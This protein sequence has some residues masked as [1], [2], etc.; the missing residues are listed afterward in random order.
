MRV[1]R[2]PHL[3][4]GIYGPQG[5]IDPLPFV[6][7]GKSTP[8]KIA[9]DTSRVGDTLRIARQIGTGIARHS[10]GVVE[11]AHNNG[12]RIVL[13]DSSRHFLNKKDVSPLGRLRTLRLDQPRMLYA[14]PDTSAA[15][16]TLL[17]SGEPTEVI[18]EYT[19]FLL[20]KR[21]L[22]GWISR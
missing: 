16:I 19:D 5:A 8:P 2:P 1:L 21:S 22:V 4:F 11:A 7:P 12:Y 6:R 15:I 10:P 14:Q 3:H 13:P 9:A 18:A 17:P 20:I